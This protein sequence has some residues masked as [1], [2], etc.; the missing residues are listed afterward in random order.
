MKKNCLKVKGNNGRERIRGIGSTMRISI[1]DTHP[2]D[3]TRKTTQVLVWTQKMSS[4]KEGEKRQGKG[5]RQAVFEI[6][7]KQTLYRIFELAVHQVV[8]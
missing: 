3:S 1:V 7:F 2:T 5:S 6:A 8:W 4:I